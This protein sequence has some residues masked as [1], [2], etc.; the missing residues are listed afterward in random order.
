MKIFYFT[1]LLWL[2]SIN[3]FSQRVL[4]GIVTTQKKI[5]ISEVT[6]HVNTKVTAISNENGSFNIK[7]PVGNSTLRF[8]KIGFKPR[9]LRINDSTTYINIEMED[10]IQDLKEIVISTGYQTLPKERATGSFAQVDQKTFNQQ[11][12]TS[13]L[14][15]LPAVTSGLIADNMSTSEGGKYMIRGLST[16]NGPKDP[17]IVI[18]NFPYDG[19]LNNI[20]PNDVESITVLKDAAAASIWGARAGNGVIVIVT[21]RGRFRQSL[22]IDFNSNITIGETPNLHYL[23]QLT[24]SEFIDVEKGLF[25]QGFYDAMIEADNKPALSPVVELMQLNKNGLL[26]DDE[27]EKQIRLFS[28]YDF[29]DDFNKYIYRPSVNQQY[30]LSLNGGTEKFHWIFSGGYDA[31]KDNVAAK[32]NRLNIRFQNTYKLLKNLDVTTGVYITQSSSEDGRQNFGEIS[33][34]GIYP[35]ARLVNDDGTPIPLVRDYSQSYLN[36]I[37]NNK[38]LDWNYYPL[39]EHKNIQKTTDLNDIVLNTGISYK[40]PFGLSADIKYQYEKQNINGKND[41]GSNSYVSRN[42]VNLYTQLDGDIVSKKIPAGGILDQSSSVMESHNMRGQINFDQNFGRHRITALS[43]I[44][45]RQNHTSSQVNRIYGYKENSLTFGQ[46]DYT[47]EYPTLISQDEAFIPNPA[48]L[49][50]VLTRYISMF[51]NGAYTFDGK[52]T[53]SASARNDAS[54]LFGVNINNKWNPLWSAGLSWEISKEGFYNFSGIPYLR[55]RTTYGYSGNVDPNMSAVTTISYRLT[56]PYTFLP[57]AIFDNY[58]N[59]SLKWETTGIFNTGIDFS[60]KGNRLSGSIEYYQKKGTDLFGT[61]PIDYTAGVGMTMLK[62]VASMKGKGVDIILNS[63]NTTGVFRWNTNLNFSYN[64]DK[65][66]KYYLSNRRASPFVGPVGVSGLEGSPVYSLFSY[67][68]A[69]LNPETGM[70]RGYLNGDISEDYR[71]ITGNGT[72]VEDLKLNGSALP[73]YFGSIGNALTY[74]NLSLDVRVL[75]KLGYY[76]RSNSIAYE[77][78]Y[79]SWNGHSDFSHRWQHKGD[80]KITNV[81]AMAYPVPS[82]MDTFYSNSEVLVLKGDQIRLQYINLNYS[83]TQVNI[84]SLPV[85]TLN[86][87]FNINNIGIIWKANKSGIDPDFYRQ[88]SLVTPRTYSMG[89][90]ANF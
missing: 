62:N 40:L 26:S 8:N 4:S 5:A 41:F 86:I 73:K 36:A 27:L 21:K 10:D 61:Y 33:S 85:K 57:Y 78:L 34:G 64:T 80:E 11:I 72:Q 59:P 22:N 7:V 90:R 83:L 74:K 70:P 69:G 16:I 63:V 39:E 60:S 75:F 14:E 89:L 44:E 23:P 51:A 25:K 13:V 2:F 31:N 56:S 84:P 53:L 45:F 9:I 19:D 68:W 77:S 3:A 42:L 32:Y 46:V 47:S 79:N 58:S 82:G 12:T 15:R 87:Y 1:I 29:R 67:K 71:Q 48:D 24:S 6:I 49:S 17:L 37:A 30:A 18:D 28:T 35:Y 43:G 66:T 88:N 54:N 76:F 52:Y 50:D 65:I 81:P 38:L 55:L 20:N